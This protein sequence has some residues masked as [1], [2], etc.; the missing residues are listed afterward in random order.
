VTADSSSVPS[1]ERVFRIAVLGRT[2]EHLGVQMYKRRDTAI[3]ELVANCWDAGAQNVWV[4]LPAA[5]Y[6]RAASVIIVEDDGTGMSDEDVE[7]HYLVVGRNRRQSGEGGATAGAGRRVM[8]RKGIGKLAGFGIA[9]VM[10][11]TTWRDS[12]STSLTLDI[13]KLK[14]GE[15]EM[16]NIDLLGKVEP[17]PPGLRNPGHGTRLVLRDLKHTTAPAV[18]RLAEALA[19]RFSTTVRG[20]MAIF[21][22]DEPIGEPEINWATRRPSPGVTPDFETEV[23]GSGKTVRYHYG[24][25]K[26]VL[27]SSELRGFTIMTNGKTAQA[28]PFFFNVET[29][30]TGQHGTKYMSGTVEADFLDD[31]I[32]DDS[33]L[34]S[35]DRQEIDWEAPETAELHAWGEELTRKA[36][37]EFR[38]F[39]QVQMRER[40]LEDDQLRGRLDHLDRPSRERALSLLGNLGLLD[41]DSDRELDLASNLISAF[42]YQHFHDFISDLEAVEEKPE[43]LQFLLEQIDGWKAIEGRA[44]LEVIKGRIS[45]IDK[46]HGLIVTGAPETAH[47]QGDEN[48]HD[49]IADFPWLL[50][51]EW[52][53]LAEERSISV[54][55]RDW[56]RGDLADQLTGPDGRQRYDFLA[57]G[58]E[59]GLVLVEIKRADYAPTIDDVQ[60]LIKYKANLQRAQ[61]RPIT[62]VF[63]SSNNFADDVSDYRDAGFPQLLSWADIHSRT[64]SYY[65][66]YRA[67]LEGDIGDPSFHAKA[68]EVA[69]TREVLEHGAYRGRARR[70]AGLGTQDPIR[71]DLDSGASTGGVGAPEAGQSEVEP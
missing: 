40:V 15:T 70:E 38:E 19:R 13:R 67:L 56:A 22:N 55:L 71:A 26:T 65:E 11:L 39:K 46:F 1:K 9:S 23:L 7:D 6:D 54:Q 18:D 53:V 24:F 16:A 3:A 69:R 4:S 33:D 30:A 61:A 51:P 42:E 31:G 52:Q 35:T 41:N 5:E 60:R 21:V 59:G 25:S 57:L 68:T 49:L 12:T 44:I 66:H 47:I 43:Q 28:P 17:V 58:D 37:R 64:K 36:L 29:T 20:S 50:D 48:V 27:A 63:I 14:L 10:E 62:A 34:V 32:D 8:G 2:L 45:I